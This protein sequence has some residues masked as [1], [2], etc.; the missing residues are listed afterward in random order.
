MTDHA[1]Q[2]M[3]T[4]RVLVVRQNSDQILLCSDGARLVL[5]QVAI[6]VQ[7]R[8]APNINRTVKEVSGLSVVSLYEVA[9]S[10][11]ASSGALPCHAAVAFEPAENLPAGARWASMRS[12]NPGLFSSPA[13]FLAVD[14]FRLRLTDSGK[15]RAAEPFLESDWFAKVTGWVQDALR[16]YSLRLAGTFRQLNSSSTFSLIRFETNRAPVWFKA[17]G[18]PNLRE[19]SIT[20][21]LARL[22]P[23]HLPRI[24][25]SQPAWHAWLA[26]HAPDD[27][28]LS[29]GGMPFWELAATSLARLQ[30]ATIGKT[31]RL[32]EAGA[33]DLGLSA[34]LSR[35]EPFFQFIA[36]SHGSVHPGL[37]GALAPSEISSLQAAVRASLE[38]LHELGAIGTI[39]HMDLNSG[40]IFCETAGAVF[41]DWA[42]AFAGC[43]AFSYEY[44]RQHFRRAPSPEPL[45]EERL[46]AAYLV[47]WRKVSGEALERALLVAPLG[48]LFA[49][50]V[51]VWL[52]PFEDLAVRRSRLDYLL[53]LVQKMK[54]QATTRETE[55]VSR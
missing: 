32:V 52:A 21:A 35:V 13:D 41:L 43:A 49:Y 48:A 22:C 28:L 44:L 27:P 11:G 39:G 2:A 45:P 14:A 17:V 37:E 9:L 29:K 16:P 47:P 40:N 55:S 4:W 3:E 50:A 23:A 5:P 53:S 38:R 1:A 30:I 42:E 7:E 19:Y 54:R 36:E 20:L 24:L 25:E 34:L 6:P 26:A 18:E 51:V 8:I 33:R 15:N 31:E 46:R 10:E 12:L